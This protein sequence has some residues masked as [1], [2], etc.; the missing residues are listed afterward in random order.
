MGV[1]DGS[2]QRDID[3]RFRQL[4]SETALIELGHDRPLELVALVQEGEPER[5]ADI[6]E[7]VGILVRS[8]TRTILFTM[9][10]PWSV[11]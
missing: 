5:E 2:T 7:D 1:R 3:R 11:R 4:H 8:A 10:R 6:L 9:S